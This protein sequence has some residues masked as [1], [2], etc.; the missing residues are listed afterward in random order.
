[1]HLDFCPLDFFSVILVKI[2]ICSMEKM[3]KRWSLSGGPVVGIGNKV[4][5][6]QEDARYG[7]GVV[8]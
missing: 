6:S 2:L 1:M 8:L 5:N 7:L 4:R 3:L